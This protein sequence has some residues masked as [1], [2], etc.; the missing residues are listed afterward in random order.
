MTFSK[1]IQINKYD[2]Y[3]IGGEQALPSILPRYYEVATSCMKID[4]RSG[5][6]EVCASMNDGR[7]AF[8]LCN[9]GSLIYVIG[10]TS[11]MSNI[12][13][14]ES[15][16]VFSD[17]W[18]RLPEACNLDQYSCGT[19]TGVVKQKFIFCFG[20]WNE[21]NTGTDPTIERIL[22]LNTLIV[23]KGWAKIVIKNPT[24]QVG[25]QQGVVPLGFANDDETEF[26]FLVFGGRMSQPIM[27]QIKRTCIFKTNLDNFKDSSLVLLKNELYIE[28]RFYYN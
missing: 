4:L 5:Q 25:I 10:G 3:M 15:Y 2:L 24:N 28:D 11:K 22:R 19:T 6:V 9:I 23:K 12:K 14:C 21:Y 20:G 7:Y 18:Q 8:G 13:T 16:N 1:L 27:S 17:K 26:E